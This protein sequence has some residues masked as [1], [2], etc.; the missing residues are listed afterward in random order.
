VSCPKPNGAFYI[1]AKLPVEDAEHFARWLL[2]DFALDNETV[3]L[4]P[5]AEFYATPGKGR[6]EVRIAYV[7]NVD[8]L[9]RAMSILREGLHAY[10]QT[11]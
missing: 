10:T 3:M 2:T 7:L 9:K 8:A 4:A 6:D 5:A 11:R 1:I